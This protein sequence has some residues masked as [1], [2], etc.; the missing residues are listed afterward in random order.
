MVKNLEKMKKDEIVRVLAKVENLPTII[1]NI[2]ANFDSEEIEIIK[3]DIH[4]KSFGK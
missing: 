1:R 4:E 2:N 3:K